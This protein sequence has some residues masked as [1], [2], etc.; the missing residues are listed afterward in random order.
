LAIQQLGRDD[1]LPAFYRKEH[2]WILRKHIVVVLDGDW[3]VNSVLS[4]QEILTPSSNEHNG[5]FLRIQI[6]EEFVLGSIGTLRSVS[7]NPG[8]EVS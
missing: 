2:M 1:K 5:L 8:M 6:A 4:A 7:I 3:E